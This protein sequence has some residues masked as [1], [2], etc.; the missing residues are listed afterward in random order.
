M[1]VFIQIVKTLC[2]AVPHRPIC[3]FNAYSFQFTSFY[4]GK[5]RLFFAIM[6]FAPL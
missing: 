5:A 3:V 6:Y 4:F 1:K 2:P